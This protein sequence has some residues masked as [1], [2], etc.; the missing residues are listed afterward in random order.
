AAAAKI[1]EQQSLKTLCESQNGMAVTEKAPATATTTTVDPET[2]RGFVLQ[3]DPMTV[4]L[5][6]GHYLKVGVAL[7]L[8]KGVV[9]ETAKDDGLG[10][11]ALD[12]TISALSP[13]TMADLGK[14]SAREGVKQKLGYDVCEAYNGEALTVFFTDFV[15]Q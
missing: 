13:R 1:A 10:A 14:A 7:Q 2:D 15:M 9:V 4:N 8:K 11:K 3:M 5:A 6:D 12:M